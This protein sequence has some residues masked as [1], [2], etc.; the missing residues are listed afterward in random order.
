MTAPKPNISLQ[1][2]TAARMAALQCLYTLSFADIAP[3]PERQVELLKKRLTDNRDEQKLV[4]GMPI[5]PNYKF[6]L[7]LLEGVKIWRSEINM[8][9]NTNLTEGW[10]RDRLSPVLI[11][12]LQCAIFELFYDKDL[13]A[14]IVIDEYCGLTSRFFE[15]GE[16][17]FVHG[18]LSKLAQEHEG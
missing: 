12:I 5:E 3:T 18:I 1:K 11:A 13:L 14:R 17:G 15:D 2:K 9:I 10:T 4:V 8:H 6:V 16:V 7:H